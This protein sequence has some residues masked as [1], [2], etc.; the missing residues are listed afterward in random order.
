MTPSAKSERMLDGEFVVEILD[1]G[2]LKL[3]VDSGRVGCELT[4][5]KAHLALKRLDATRLLLGPAAPVAT[6]D[7]APIP[8]SWLPLPM[9]WNTLDSI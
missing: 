4:D 7:L 3:F 5:E 1:Y 6:A 2:K 8:R 9:S